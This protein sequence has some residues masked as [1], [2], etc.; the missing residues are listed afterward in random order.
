M[1]VVI[2]FEKAV[3]IARDALK[4]NLKLGTFM[5]DDR[6][7]VAN[8]MFYVVNVG[9]REYLVDGD[10]GYAIAGDVTLVSKETGEL[11]SAPSAEV[12]TD[13]T[14]RIRPNPDTAFG[15]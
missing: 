11:S 13:P 5:I 12:A 8:D 2:G 6:N 7:I 10:F 15:S 1:D 3:L 9:A 14:L 4:S